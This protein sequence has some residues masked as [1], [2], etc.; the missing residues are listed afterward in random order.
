MLTDKQKEDRHIALSGLLIEFGASAHAFMD[1]ILNSEMVTEDYYILQESEQ[2][3][4]QTVMHIICKRCKYGPKGN[5][6]EWKEE[7][8]AVKRVIK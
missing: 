7:I 5:Q 8:E 6:K 1:R 4:P 2:A 3:L